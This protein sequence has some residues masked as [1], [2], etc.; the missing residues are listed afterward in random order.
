[1]AF[2]YQAD[3]ETNAERMERATSE[4]QTVE[5]TRAV[6]S[7][8]VNGV[9]VTEG[10]IIGLLNDRLVAS[11]QDYTAV[12]MQVLDQAQAGDCEILTIY[13]GQDATQKEASALADQIVEAY[14][15]LETEVHEG[16]QAHYRYILS[17]E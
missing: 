11:G 4:I 12:V 1:L 3:I 14:P 15:N 2:N 10:D 13:F 7:T 6:R 9:E 8:Q 16:D 17:L 5:V